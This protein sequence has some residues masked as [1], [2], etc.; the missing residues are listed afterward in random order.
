MGSG[1]SS[2]LKGLQFALFGSGNLSSLLRYGQREGSVFVEFELG[3]HRYGARRVLRSVGGTVRS[4]KEYW[5]QDGEVQLLSA[6]QLNEMV[7]TALGL[8]PSERARRVPIWELAFYI[9]Q[10][11]LKA[12]LSD[13]EVRVKAIESAFDIERYR[14][15][16]ENAQD[17]SIY[18]QTQSK[19][20]KGFCEPLP[21]KM[22]ELERD[23]RDLSEL[24]PELAE[25]EMGIE[26]AKLEEQKARST[27]ESLLHA[28]AS[29]TSSISSLDEEL[30][31]LQSDLD[32]REARTIQ[33]STRIEELSKLMEEKLELSRAEVP[34]HEPPEK[35]DEEINKEE[36]VLDDLKEALRWLRVKEQAMDD[37]LT[38]LDSLAVEQ[39]R[40]PE[41]VQADLDRAS[42]ELASV[43][44]KHEFLEGQ[45]VRYREMQKLGRCPL[46]MREASPELSQSLIES[47][48]GELERLER[49]AKELEERSRSLEQELVLA[50]RAEEL[51]RR[52][53]ELE[54][55]LSQAEEDVSGYLLSLSGRGKQAKVWKRLMLPPED[56]AETE[57]L[58]AR[59]RLSHAISFLE[60]LEEFSRDTIVELKRKRNLSI[61]LERLAAQ[62][63]SAIS[64]VSSIA[65][66]I[67]VL[68][69]QMEDDRLAVSQLAARSSELSSKKEELSSSL[70][71][72]QPE[73]KRAEE[74][75]KASQEKLGELEKRRASLLQKKQDL[76]SRVQSLGEEVADMTKAKEESD[77]LD[78]IVSWLQG[79]FLQL[80]SLIE[81]TVVAKMRLEFEERFSHMFSL[82]VEDPMKKVSLDEEFS[83]I[84]EHSGI[85]MDL[86]EGPSGGERSSVALAYRLA[87][88]EMAR[89]VAGLKLDVI[90]LDE[91]TDG[92]SSEQLS[93]FKD[94]IEGL[95]AKQVILVSHEKEL[96]S[97]ADHVVLVTK[98]EDVS[99]VEWI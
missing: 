47:S 77:R 51:S 94:L 54:R 1:K 62:K 78:E 15:V 42:R 69:Q 6:T 65:K 44:A 58:P 83:P 26:V 14:R 31:R 29:I 72:K 56:Q 12:I 28:V 86:D 88:N 74:V 76:Q 8:K 3:E 90:I 87:L 52:K 43:K 50:R 97:S 10:E 20:L 13:R 39:H 66:Q 57:G 19:H 35:I 49:N 68:R 24:E 61:E 84:I 30:R 32:S 85:E 33:T 71:G 23:R 5:V 92:F 63:E 91:P 70:S 95:D 99:S 59:E 46:C 45:V 73:L 48:L 67:E 7:F 18:L 22:K 64:Q 4:D 27:Y 21:D 60:R 41:D 75:W 36:S 82:M 93:K 38:E 81:Q 25:L 17:L 53:A 80:V 11:K 37:I 96:E 9:S 55:Q 40:H 16:R 79:A 34:A 2:I 98:D 89:E